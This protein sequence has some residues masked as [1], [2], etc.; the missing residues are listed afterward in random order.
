MQPNEKLLPPGPRRRPRTG[1]SRLVQQVLSKSPGGSL[2]RRATRTILAG[3]VGAAVGGCATAPTTRPQSA[4]VAEVERVLDAYHEAASRADEK[5][6]FD[7]M[8]EDSVF[9]GTDAT[10]R[11]TKKDFQAFAQPHFEKP[12]AWTF[13]PASRNVSVAPGGAHAWFDELLDSEHLGQCRGTGVLRYE[14][15]QWRIA[16]YHLTIPVP[17]DLADDVVEQIRQ[18][19]K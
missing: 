4:D 18:L 7:L 15:G 5:T 9:L 3:L 8:T 6:Y 14:S 1:L 16:Q 17:N 11:W 10:E 2:R 13:V 19:D 12:T